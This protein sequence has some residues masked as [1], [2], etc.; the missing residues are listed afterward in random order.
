MEVFKDLKGAITS[1][2]DLVG[3]SSLNTF[4]VSCGANCH[5]ALLVIVKVLSTSL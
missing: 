3:Y 5:L 2:A 1:R 4:V